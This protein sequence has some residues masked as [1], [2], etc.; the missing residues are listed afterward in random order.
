MA[1]RRSNSLPP[2]QDGGARGSDQTQG[3]GLL[4]GLLLGG[5]GNRGRGAGRDRGARGSD[6]AEDPRHV[7]PFWS[8]RA[9]EEQRLVEARPSGLPEVGE[10]NLFDDDELQTAG[11]TELQERSQDRSLPRV[12][13]DSWGLEADRDASLGDWLQQVNWPSNGPS[14]EDRG[15]GEDRGR[16]V[17][18]EDLPAAK[19]RRQASPQA[20][21]DLEREMEKAM[22]D[23]L[24][25]EN[26]DLKKQVAELRRLVTEGGRSTRREEAPMWVPMTPAATPPANTRTTPGGTV[27]PPGTPPDLPRIPDWPLAGRNLDAEGW[28]IQDG[29]DGWRVL[30]VPHPPTSMGQPICWTSSRA[31]QSPRPTCR[32]NSVQHPCSSRRPGTS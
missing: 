8:E 24:A 27:V 11:G 5:G 26:E 13:D 25:Q 12:P 9:R 19:V 22:V 6:Q 28:E 7:N 17:G 15:P 23:T 3:Q 20:Q 16:R 1:H 29:A 21:R 18:K 32:P 4:D 10:L 2:L 31:S 14:V 30:E